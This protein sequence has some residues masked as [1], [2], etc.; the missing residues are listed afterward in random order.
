MAVMTGVSNEVSRKR[1]RATAAASAVQAS[2]VEEHLA[3]LRMR[4]QVRPE[5]C[6]LT[7]VRGLQGSA[8]CTFL[9]ARFAP[10]VPLNLC[11]A[12]SCAPGRCV[13]LYWKEDHLLVVIVLP[14]R[15]GLLVLSQFVAFSHGTAACAASKASS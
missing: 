4:W 1:R 9:C 5:P 2:S 10:A 7:R 6:A 12:L 13:L 14:A 8:C 11:L 15:R 3:A